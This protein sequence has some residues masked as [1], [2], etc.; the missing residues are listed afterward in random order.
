M[1]GFCVLLDTCHRCMQV[2]V[3]EF[4]ERSNGKD[5]IKC[6][7]IVERDSQCGI[8]IGARGSALKALAT[9]AR[10]DIEEFLGRSVYLE[11]EVVL[12]GSWRKDA[13]MLKAFGY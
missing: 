5:Y 7:L 2:N 11:V 8:L 13:A 12:G 1:R 9:R 6:E 10:V 3:V 4:K